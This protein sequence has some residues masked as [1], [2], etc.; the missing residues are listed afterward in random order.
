MAATGIIMLFFVIGHLIG[1]LQMFSG[2]GDAQTPAKI[3]TYAKFLQSLGSLL[4][5]ARIG[6]IVALVAHVVAT[7]KIVAEN[8]AA[9][10]GN[11]QYVKRAQ[12][13]IS[14]RTMI[15]SGSYILCFIIFHLMHFTF[16]T[17]HPEFKTLHDAHGL[18]DV[19]AM[20]LI[21]FS[22]IPASL[23]Y[24]VGMIL[25]CSHLSHGVESVFQTLGVQTQKTRPVIQIVGRSL[26]VI[27]AIGYISM[28][29]A[30]LAGFGKDYREQKVAQA[31]SAAKEAK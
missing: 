28:P 23:F 12:A 15:W 25:L 11:V 17:V 27:L 24:I 16:Q 26:A 1:N 9:K 29:V 31:H 20:M 7:I 18:H 8:R 3:N 14:T 2:P 22:S 19:Y 21:G 4:W 6:L 5:V 13:R 10:G 30:V